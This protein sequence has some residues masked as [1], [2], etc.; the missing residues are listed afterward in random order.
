MPMSGSWARAMSSPG[1]VRAPSS[2]R[3]SPRPRPGLAVGRR[4]A[5]SDPERSGDQFRNSR[6]HSRGWR[7]SISVAVSP[8]GRSSRNAPGGAQWQSSCVPRAP[9]TVFMAI[10]RQTRLVYVTP[11][12]QYP[13][14]LSMSLRRRV[15]LLEWAER[16]L[17]AIVEDDYDSEFRFGG[18]PLDA[19]HTIDTGGRVIY[20]GSFSKTM[21]PSL[22]LGFVVTPPSLTKAVR[23]AKCL[24]DWH[25]ALPLQGA[26]TQFIE[27]GAFARHIRKM[28]SVYQARHE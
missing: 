20:V 18:R 28:R 22:R 14:G 26:M 5:R 16:Y 23:A 10:P 6:R 15:E 9:P 13:L 4:R 1:S 8:T 2:A 17:A 21:L 25:T 11:S 24:T 27:S 19:L 12:H 7:S 3:T